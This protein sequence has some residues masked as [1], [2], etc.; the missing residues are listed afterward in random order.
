[1]R[2]IAVCLVAVWGMA[3]LWAGP[4]DA[5]LLRGETDRPALAYR[6]GEEM[7][8]TLTL[9]NGDAIERGLY[10]IRWDRSGDDGRKSSGCVDAPLAEPLVIRTSLDRPGFVRVHAVMVSKKDGK[11]YQKDAAKFQSPAREVFFDGGAGV[12]IDKLENLPE[13]KDFDAFWYRRKLRLDRVKPAVESCAETNV[14]GRADVRMFALSVRCAGPR[15]VTG[16][17]S[18]P[19]DRTRTYPAR[20][21]TCGYS[22][23]PA[24]TQMPRNPPRDEIQ[25]FVN[26]HGCELN[27]E[28][29]Y[30]REFAAAI[31]SGGTGYAFDPKQNEDAESAYFSGMTYRVMQALRYLKTRPEWD[32]RNLIA[33]GGSQGGLQ[34]VWAAGL[35]PDVTL[36]EPSITWCCD[37]GGETKGRNRGT[38]YVGYRP[39]LGYYDAVNVARRIPR[40]C[41]VNIT[42]AGLGD[43]VCPPSGLAML[44]N[45]MTCPKSIRWVQGSTHGYV[46]PGT[47]GI[48]TLSAP[49]ASP[50][51]WMAGRQGAFCHYLMNAED[52]ARLGEYDVAGV[53]R[54]LVERKVGYF[55]LTLGQ[56]TGYYLAP[57]RTYETIAGYAPG[58]RCS[59]RDLPREL[60]QALKPHGIRLMLYLP[61]QVANGDLTAAVRFGFPAEGA[62]RSDGKRTKDRAFTEEGVLNWAKV[63]AE[64]SERYGEDVAAWWFDGAYDFLGFDERIAQLYAAA[65]KRCNPCAAVTFNPG[66]RKPMWTKYADYEAGEENDL[67]ETPFGGARTAEGLQ[68]HFFTFL[69]ATWGKPGRHF[70]DEAKL[71]SWIDGAR[72]S[73][74]AVTF[75][76]PAK[77]PDGTLLLDVW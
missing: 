1:M 35:D 23:P 24:G 49:A 38:W 74:W 46:P 41:R 30:Y 75:D 47:N 28:P 76:I 36:A 22:P 71:S 27:R 17:L 53:V 48:W 64:W 7:V 14:P 45:A 10:E 62:V 26:A 63:I 60:I 12:E 13:P 32:G 52:F 42:R 6:P 58:S 44:Y 15:P 57:N 9:E 54:Q 59:T 33:S 20:L 5:A 40:T 43:Y 4:Y 51:D 18:V 69:G 8:F 50:A 19:A 2:L 31:R 34:T 39:A 73:G 56:N 11:P 70:T 67:P 21:V 55:G 37:L 16:W 25:F 77:K 29:E 61:C 72:K 65:V 68:R 66:V 3:R